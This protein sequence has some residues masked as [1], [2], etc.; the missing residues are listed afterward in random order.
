MRFGDFII[1]YL[2]ECH[3]CAVLSFD[4][5]ALIGLPRA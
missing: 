4:D 2:P 1:G 5:P 3:L